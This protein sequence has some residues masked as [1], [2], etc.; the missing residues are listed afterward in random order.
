MAKDKR[1]EFVVTD[2]RLF[3]PEGDVR[4]DIPKEDEPK[5]APSAPP[6]AKPGPQPVEPPKAHVES[7]DAGTEMPLPPTAE[8]QAEQK[9]AYDESTRRIDDQ[10]RSRL[11]GRLPKDFEM[12]FERLVASLYM[13]ALMQLGLVHAQGEQPRADVLGAR[14]TIDTLALLQDKTKGNLTD[15]ERSMLQQCLYELRM[16]WLE[17]TNAIAQGPPPGAPGSA[18]KK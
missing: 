7:F 17:L 12:T 9:S 5:P 10:L 11:E 18:E 3:T 8:E 16:A 14:Q 1:E 4:P 2:R 15:A 6:T 13:T